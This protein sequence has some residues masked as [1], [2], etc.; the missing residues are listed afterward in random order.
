MRRISH[1]RVRIAVFAVVGA[2][3]FSVQLALLTLIAHAGV[4]RPVAD[5]I[6]FALSAQLNF[7]LSMRF[8]W[9][10]RQAIGRRDI[11][12]RWLAYNMTAL[13]SLAVNTAVFTVAYQA[14]GTIAAALLGVLAGTAVVYLTC[15]YIIFRTSRAAARAMAARPPLAQEALAQQA[16]AQQT[17]AVR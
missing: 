5:A 4:A 3:C 8:T 9:R 13:L 16:V 6:G 1:A 7:V 14:A 10:D 11:G 17:G 2:L 12:V 15:N